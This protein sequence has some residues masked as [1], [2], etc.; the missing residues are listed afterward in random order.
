MKIIITGGHLSPA[1]SV[2]EKIKKDNVLFVGRKN[3]IIGDRAL[4]LEY[5]L[6]QKLNIPFVSIRATKFERKI[7]MYTIPS[8]FNFPLGTLQALAI[9]KKFKPNLV[10]GFGGYVSLPVIFAAKILNVPIVIHEQTLEAG[11]A[12]KIASRIAK[13]VCISWK[14]SEKFFPKAKTVLT[15]NPIRKELLDIKGARD[16][17]FNFNNN[18]PLIYITGG[19][20]G[21]HVINVFI[22][23][24][25]AKL[26]KVA[27]IIHQTGDSHE[28]QDFDRLSKNN[29][30]GYIVKKF[31]SEEELKYIYSNAS[32]VVSRSGINTITELLY[33]E[34]PSFLIPLPVGQKNEQ[35]KNA[36]FYKSLGLAEV[37]MQNELND[38]KFLKII[39]HMLKNILKYKKTTKLKNLIKRN[40]A[41][42][43][44]KVI[45]YAARS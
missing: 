11:V 44:I 28:Y 38:D 36:L 37:A 42:E 39:L 30:D 23:K 31:V 41:D 21:S 10:L 26:T 35:L 34:K 32:L 45:K 12:N 25:L 6:C 16:N 4:S 1:F 3:A 17:L 5:Q 8:I 15:G 24:N 22:E 13:K 27:N 43:I 19:S 14:S 20:L 9:L 7:T 18:L 29:V 2:I 40:A 33:F